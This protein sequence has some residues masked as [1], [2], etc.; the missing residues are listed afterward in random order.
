MGRAKPSLPF[1]QVTILQR[2]VAELHRGFDDVIVV[3]APA[4]ACGAVALTGDTR[5]VRL[6]RDEAEYGGPVLALVRGLAVAKNEIAFVCSCDLPLLRMEVAQ[7]L[8]DWLREMPA[9]YAAVIPEIGG[10]LQPLAA[11][12]RRDCGPVIAAIAVGG[13]RRLTAIAMRL[14]TRRAGEA[15]MG[16]LDPELLSFLNVNTPEDYARAL[17][18]AGM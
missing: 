2:M 8:C 10:R 15:E 11:A 12:Y 13:E 18:L 5:S 17:R 9:S 6:V 4:E 1:G 16:P 14:N 7:A 3:A